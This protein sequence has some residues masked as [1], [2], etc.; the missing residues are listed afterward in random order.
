MS[1]AGSG[2]RLRDVVDRLH[3]EVAELRGSRRRLAQ[4]SHDDRRGIERAFHDGVQQ[5]LIAFAV[6]LRRL[7]GLVDTD[8]TAAKALLDEMATNVREALDEAS[9]LAEGIYP[10]LLDASGFASALR[11]AAGRADVAAAVD[12]RVGTAYSAELVAAVYWTCIDALSSAPPGSRATVRVLDADG[13]M[14][15]EIVVA[16]HLAAGRIERLCDRIEALDG[17]VTV[18]PSSDRGSRVL[19][20]LPLSQ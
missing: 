3:S 4:A 12:V 13:V 5:H 18:E 15:F 1:N 7:T 20:W 17:R 2:E 19:G 8:P 6:Q 10:P 16:G 14:T 9:M 11:S